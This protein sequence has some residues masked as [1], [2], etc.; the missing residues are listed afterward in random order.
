M[1]MK[2]SFATLL[3]LLLYCTA[4]AEPVQPTSIIASYEVFKGRMKIGRIDE[5]YT[6]DNDHYTLTS[7][8]QAT[9]WLAFF[10]PGKIVLNSS[11]QV[12]E[13]GLLPSRFSDQ[14]EGHEDKNRGAE[15][16][17]I[18]KQLTMTQ[19]NQPIVVTLPASTQDRLSAMYQFLFLSLKTG[20]PLEF[21][22]TNGG[23][24]DEYQYTVANGGKLVTPAG[25]FNTLYLD[26]Q[27]KKGESRTEIWLAT[28][29]HNL[30]CKMT[31]TDADGDQLTQILSSIEIR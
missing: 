20:T 1:N 19:H 8:T 11:G 27:A 6:R 7:T 25:E 21:P 29:R 5:R 12:G 2:L 26:S 31:L 10:N 23:K 22:M 15:F 24:L 17:W 16:D 14:R 9:G 13:H 30:A 18:G 28:E 4:F 3:C